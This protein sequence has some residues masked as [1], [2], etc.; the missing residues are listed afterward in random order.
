MTKRFETADAFAFVDHC[1]APAD[2]RAF[3]ARLRED[4]AL[5]RQVALWQSQNEAIRAAYGAPASA[6]APLELAGNANENVSA[7]MKSAILKQPGA[8]ARPANGEAR[9]APARAASAAPSA[10]FRALRRLATVAALAA[11]LLVVSGPGGPTPPHDRLAEAGLAA[12]RAFAAAA[13]A[14]IEF[15]ARDPQALTKWLTPQ[16]VRGIAVPGFSSDALTLLGAR[17]A[18]GSRASAAFL[19]Y[20]DRSGERVGLLIEPLDDPA[21]SKPSLRRSDG[22]SLAAWTG[23]GHGFVAAGTDLHEVALLT[24]LVEEGPAAR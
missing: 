18:P 5:R 19:V 9:A 23:A 13:D 22:V 6:R 24:R 8:A 1:L 12:Y 2:R 3:E 11:I 20:Q 15:R 21:P 10:R 16:F 17:V 7:W 14:P 4:P